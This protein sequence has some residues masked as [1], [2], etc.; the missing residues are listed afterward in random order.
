MN[1]LVIG[2]TGFLSAAVVRQLGAAGHE[3]TIFTRGQRPAPEGVR[4]IT[5]DRNDHEGF[6]A[7]LRGSRFDAVVD[8]ICYRPEDAQADARAFSE[9]GAHLVMIS[10]DF[11]YGA[12]RTLPMN[13]ETPRQ[14]LSRYGRDKALCEDLL[15]AAGREGRLPVTVLRP[16]HIMGAGGQL[17]S[18][19][20]QGRDPM[21]LDRIRRRIPLILLDGGA[22]LVQP[23]VHDDV[24]RACAAVAGRESTFGEAYNV[25]GPDA[26]TSR[27]YYEII[28][29][30]LGEPLAVHSLPAAVY[31]A[32][33]PEKAP[34]AHHRTYDVCKLERDSGFLPATDVN[35][36][37]FSMIDWLEANQAALPYRPDPVDQAAMELCARF[38]REAGGVLCGGG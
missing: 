4:R 23:V 19:S 33:F 14:A 7:R 15:F 24:G 5:G 28:S 26:V 31:A 17:G 6:A 8:C 3:V 34:F 1:I 25:A 35:Y 21:L 22:L 2:G 29:T 27:R 32:A 20:L 16:P 38:E 12:E 10:T 13:E 30:A 18:G 37:I 9:S 11:V 36:A